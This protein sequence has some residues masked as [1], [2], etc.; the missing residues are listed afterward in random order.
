MRRRADALFSDSVGGLLFGRG[1]EEE[2]D[3][4]PEDTDEDLYAYAG[5][6]HQRE[7]RGRR[8]RGGP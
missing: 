6:D 8:R 7:G 3:V 2:G 5:D 1:V 4:V